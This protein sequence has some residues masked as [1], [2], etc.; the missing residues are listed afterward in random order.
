MR[1]MRSAH[2]RAQSALEGVSDLLLSRPSQ[3]QPAARQVEVAKS[4]QSSWTAYAKR[5]KAAEA[6]SSQQ[7]N[8]ESALDLKALE[9]LQHLV[10]LL[11]SALEAAANDQTPRSPQGAAQDDVI[12]LRGLLETLA[13][14]VSGL[15]EAAGS[16]GGSGKVVGRFEWVDGVLVKAL[17]R[18]EWILLENANLCNPTVLD[19][20][21]PLLEPGGTVMVNERGLVEGQPMVVTAHPNFRLFLTLDPAYGELSRAMRNRGIEVFVMPPDWGEEGG[22]GEEKERRT[23][24]Q[25]MIQTLALAGIPGKALPEAMARAHAQAA[26]AAAAYAS[27]SGALL[28]LRDLARWTELLNELLE[29]GADVRTAIRVSWGHTHGAK[30]DSPE[31]QSEAE[32]AYEQWLATVQ[33]PEE[34]PRS[35]Q[36]AKPAPGRALVDS[37]EQWLKSAL[38]QAEGWPTPLT[39]ARWAQESQLAVVRRDSAYLRFLAAQAG[40]GEGAQKLL[41]MVKGEGVRAQLRA[42][43]ERQASQSGGLL[44]NLLGENY[45]AGGGSGGVSSRALRMLWFAAVCLMQRASPLDAELRRVWVQAARREVPGMQVPGE[46]AGL[47]DVAAAVLEQLQKHPVTRQLEDSRSALASLVGAA[48]STVD[49]QPYDLRLLRLAAPAGSTVEAHLSLAGVLADSWALARTAIQQQLVMERGYKRGGTG[50]PV[51]LVVQ[52]F[53]YSTAPSQRARAQVAHRVVPWLYPLFQA[54]HAWEDALLRSLAAEGFQGPGPREDDMEVDSV[55]G[56]AESLV[57]IR[58]DLQELNEKLRAVQQWRYSLWVWASEREKLQPPEA[59]LVRWDG[60]KRA[61][62]AL[63]ATRVAARVEDEQRE[64]VTSGVKLMDEALTGGEGALS[65]PLLWKHGGRPQAPG[66]LELCLEEAAVLG[67]CDSLRVRGSQEEEG[68]G[69]GLAGGAEVRRLA[70][71]GLCML[72]WAKGLGKGPGGGLETGRVEGVYNLL[73]Q[74]IDSVK[75]KLSR[76]T[77]ADPIPHTL[78]EAGGWVITPARMMKSKSVQGGQFPSE[79]LRWGGARALAMQ[80]VALYETASLSSQAALFPSLIEWAVS[81]G[82]K[83]SQ[84][85]PEDH[86]QLLA[87]LDTWL[88]AGGRSPADFAPAQQLVWLSDAAVG[89]GQQDLGLAI[90]AAVHEF[91]FR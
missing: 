15:L 51:S 52:S 85:G 73:Q 25:D 57:G 30:L 61:L 80:L 53:R 21:N 56:S 33:L 84:W 28:T 83:D 35:A 9:L 14:D 88:V 42:W 8:A 43:F 86:R 16:G 74:Q 6:G 20:L 79:L 32:A 4:L 90:R 46:T 34:V 24:W 50:E 66:S 78:D 71:Q 81:T 82:M 54:V 26:E 69:A 67:L 48:Q 1:R 59:F 91:V 39:S 18:G 11:S 37:A 60:L 65:K 38:V 40:A 76:P 70:V 89:G 12:R 58:G 62:V 13:S 68:G 27:G 55:G 45:G 23:Q 64:K 49:R 63:G 17:E 5:A 41:A 29:R 36:D 3:A 22:H 7:D 47:L 19:R 75:E 2:S 77:E 44:A 10:A 87:W 31:A 72:Q